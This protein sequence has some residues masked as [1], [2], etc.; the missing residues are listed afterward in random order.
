MDNIIA[1]TSVEVPGSCKEVIFVMDDETE[2]SVV[3]HAGRVIGSGVRGK[4]DTD[5]KR[6]E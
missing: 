3:V 1:G 6:V 2:I 5:I 4:Q